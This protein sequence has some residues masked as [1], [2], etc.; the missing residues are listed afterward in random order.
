[1]G[2]AI[3]QSFKDAG[4]K[5]NMISGPATYIPSDIPVEKVESAN[6]ML[7]AVKKHHSEADIVVFAAAVSDY[8]PK[9]PAL[10][11]IKKKED[12]LQI[13]L[14]KNPDI[15]AEL[16]KKKTSQFHIGF[17][18]ETTNEEV[19][20]KEKL[21]KKNFDLIVLNSLN[22]TGAGFQQ[23]T[24]KVTFFDKNN[25]ELKFELKSKLDVAQDIVNYV[26]KNLK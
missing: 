16:G 7:D 4:A 1:M 2:S 20:A 19:H 13:D 10:E 23:D 21:K 3:A 14:I 18:L 8:R 5:V 12:T 25:N 6:E 9:N 26:I 22:D 24:N 17:A 15:A 11:K